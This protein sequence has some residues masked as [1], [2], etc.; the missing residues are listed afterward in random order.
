MRSGA[1][2]TEISV[3]SCLALAKL[4]SFPGG[5]TETPGRRREQKQTY[6]N[7]HP[8]WVFPSPALS[9]IP[10]EWMQSH[11]SGRGTPLSLWVPGVGLP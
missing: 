3:F 5:K 11:E 7:A 1:P 8:E 6:S 9:W 2:D 4:P 10:P